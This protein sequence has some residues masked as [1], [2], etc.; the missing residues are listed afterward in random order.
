MTGRVCSACRGPLIEID[1][2]GERL[3]GCVKCNLWRKDDEQNLRSL[4]EEDL[5]AL[6][7][8]FQRKKKR[9]QEG[10]A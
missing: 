10:R 3:T 7:D 4:A 6:R 5:E 2:Y 1:Y 8:Q 9:P